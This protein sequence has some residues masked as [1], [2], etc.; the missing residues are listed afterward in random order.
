MPI[1]SFM[2][3]TLFKSS[4]HDCWFSLSLKAH[5]C[6]DCVHVNPR[7]G[8]G[9]ANGHFPC[10]RQSSPPPRLPGSPRSLLSVLP[11][12][13]SAPAPA[14]V[15]TQIEREISV[16][17]LHCAHNIKAMQTNCADTPH[18]PGF[19]CLSQVA[20][21]CQGKDFCGNSWFFCSELKCR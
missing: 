4:N 3:L 19:K 7:E 15:Q 14:S 1:E 2:H 18:G 8:A 6:D 16:C 12:A 5:Q 9:K 17:C 21:G 13:A 11:P 20:Q 10:T